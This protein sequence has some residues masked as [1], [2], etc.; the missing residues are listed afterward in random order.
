MRK[1]SFSQDQF[2][3]IQLLLAMRNANAD[4]QNKET[5]YMS[6]GN[7]LTRLGPNL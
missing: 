5:F 4:P 6:T 3:P 1:C 2:Q 7:L